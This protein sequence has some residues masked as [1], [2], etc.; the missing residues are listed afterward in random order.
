ME[1]KSEPSRAAICIIG[2]ILGGLF[3]CLIAVVRYYSTD[4][5]V[6]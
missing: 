1:N 3:G 5:D 4:K 6:I 2:A